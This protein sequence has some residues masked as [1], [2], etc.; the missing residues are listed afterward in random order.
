MD[1]FA[2]REPA[3]LRGWDDLEAFAAAGADYVIVVSTGGTGIFHAS[4]VARHAA[5]KRSGKTAFPLYVISDELGESPLI[6]VETSTEE[7]LVAALFTSPERARAFRE[8]AEHLNLPGSLGEIDTADGLRRH[9]LVA[10][11]AGAGYAVIDPESGLTDAVPLD[12]F[13]Q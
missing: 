12:E 9:A 7:V 13:I 1:A 4:D 10:R 11:Q 2:G 3:D 8:R 5:D 6:S